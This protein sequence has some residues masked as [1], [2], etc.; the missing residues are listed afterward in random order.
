MYAGEKQKTRTLK[1]SNV[2][3]CSV[4]RLKVSKGSPELL[5]EAQAWELIGTLLEHEKYGAFMGPLKG[6]KQV[7]QV[8]VSV[9]EHKVCAQHQIDLQGW[10]DVVCT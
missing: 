8:V 9:A 7:Y 10:G 6:L 3:R 4:G 5:E 2:G 1:I